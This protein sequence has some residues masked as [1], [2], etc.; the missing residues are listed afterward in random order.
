MQWYAV[1]D[2]ETGEITSSGTVLPDK[3]DDRLEAVPL[4][5][6]PDWGKDQWDAENRV[7]VPREKSK[8]PLSAFDLLHRM[9][10]ADI[11]PV[12]KSLGIS[13]EQLAEIKAR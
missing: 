7:L 5:R 8:K 9:T 4:P 13:D 11:E 1:C 12:L 10:A 3:L 2:K 6:E